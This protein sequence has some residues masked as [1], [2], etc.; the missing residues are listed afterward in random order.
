MPFNYIET[1]NI[2][3]KVNTNDVW[4]FLLLLVNWVAGE[5]VFVYKILKD[6]DLVYLLLMMISKVKFVFN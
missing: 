3:S 1:Y 2:E 6:W 5:F 4:T